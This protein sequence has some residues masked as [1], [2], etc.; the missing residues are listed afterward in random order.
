MIG[1]VSTVPPQNSPGQIPPLQIPPLQIPPLQIPLTV[2]DLAFDDLH[3]LEWSGGTHHVIAL[4][5]AL[6]AAL[7]GDTALV[8]IELANGKL[9]AVGGVDFR[10]HPAKGELWMLSVRETF[11]SLGLGTR[12]ISALEG[13]A[14]DH[15]CSTARIGVEHDN[16]RALA[17]YRRLGYTDVGV[18]LADWAEG[19]HRYVTVCTMLEKSL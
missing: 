7:A 2:R 12:L 3:E 1:R 13:R 19:D 11:Q 17:L 18:E 16:P 10:K 14:R 15:G 9:V 5:T 4:A 8:C 6:E